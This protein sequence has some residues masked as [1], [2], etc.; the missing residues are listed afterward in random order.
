MLERELPCLSV[1]CPT[2]AVTCLGAEA[3]GHCGQLSGLLRGPQRATPPR[4]QS[5][6]C[7]RRRAGLLSKELG[8]DP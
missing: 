3:T 5:A 2:I 7:V 4:A 6:R 8:R 1:A